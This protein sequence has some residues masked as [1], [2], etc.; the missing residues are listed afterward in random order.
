M[1]IN[2]PW[3]SNGCFYQGLRKKHSRCGRRPP[4]L[5]LAWGWLNESLSTYSPADWI[6]LEAQ[7]PFGSLNLKASINSGEN[8]RELRLG[9][10]WGRRA[11]LFN[12]TRSDTTRSAKNSPRAVPRASLGDFRSEFIDAFRL[13]GRISRS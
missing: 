8:R 1:R 10:L 9:W 2:P 3:C 4:A 12:L 11:Q 13:S 7:D 5:R 6:E